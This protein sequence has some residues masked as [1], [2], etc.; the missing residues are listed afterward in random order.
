MPRSEYAMIVPNDRVR[1]ALSG[2]LGRM[3]W[4]IAS[5]MIYQAWQEHERER[6]H[7]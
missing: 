7:D 6:D 4:N 5:E 1:T 2:C 3:F